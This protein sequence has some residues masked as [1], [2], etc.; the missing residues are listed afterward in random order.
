M[1]VRPHISKDKK[2]K[3]KHTFKYIIK[4]FANRDVKYFTYADFEK[5]S[6][7]LIGRQYSS[8]NNIINLFN[9]IR[10]QIYKIEDDKYCSKNKFYSKG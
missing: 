1:F 6:E 2:N 9:D 7:K 3:K 8:K 10:D 5:F 4:C